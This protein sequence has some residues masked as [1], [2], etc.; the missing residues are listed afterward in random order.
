MLALIR[1]EQFKAPAKDDLDIEERWWK[2]GMI[3]TY[4]NSTVRSIVSA[5]V[6]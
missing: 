5:M 1:E 6:W 2:S 3:M 4:V